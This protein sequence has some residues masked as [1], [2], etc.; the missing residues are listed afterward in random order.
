MQHERPAGTALCCKKPV[1][2]HIASQ[3]GDGEK[4]RFPLER[5]RCNFTTHLALTARFRLRRIVLQPE[6]Q[7]RNA[8]RRVSQRI[9]LDQPACDRDSV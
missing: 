3:L 4:L 5:H 7:H 8:R 1:Y 6:L 9:Q 2:L